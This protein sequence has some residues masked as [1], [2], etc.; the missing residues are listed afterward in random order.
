MSGNREPTI[1][2]P[3][4]AAAPVR[5]G[6][7]PHTMAE[8]T[9]SP[10]YPGSPTQADGARAQLYTVAAPPTP[11]LPRYDSDYK[12]D[13]RKYSEEPGSFYPAGPEPVN[14][15][16][17]MPSMTPG[18]QNFVGQQQQ[19]QMPQA[20]YQTY[21]PQ[22]QTSQPQQQQQYQAP[23]PMT[24]PQQQQQQ[25]TQIFQQTPGPQHQMSSPPPLSPGNQTSQPGPTMPMQF[26]PRNPN[27]LPVKPNGERDWSTSLC[28]CSDVG[29]CFLAWCCPCVVYGQ[30][31][32][33]LSF[34]TRN[35][36]PHPSGGDGCGSDCMIHGTLTAC[37]GIGWVL[38]IGQRSAVRAR[39]RIDS[40]GCA[41]CLCA[42]CCT[43]CSLVQEAQEI[44]Q[45]E[46]ALGQAAAPQMYVDAGKY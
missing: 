27:N 1:D 31:Q 42:W 30:I 16:M 13:E 28:A 39:Y 37:C 11:Q 18:P 3:P 34:L 24:P 19:Q 6:S 25:H 38:Q 32:T 36:A 21:Q 2:L 9:R 22:R 46:R 45:E 26:N 14:T 33:R 23:L 12:A 44:E 4:G 17:P 7:G 20:P 15:M 10:S 35:N 8:S 5:H 43:P 29:T 40:N 41:D